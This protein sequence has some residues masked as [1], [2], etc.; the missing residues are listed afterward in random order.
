MLQVDKIMNNRSIKLPCPNK[1][2]KSKILISLNDIKYNKTVKCS[3]C[4]AK[5]TLEQKRNNVSKF[6]KLLKDIPKNI[7]IKL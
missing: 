4:G 3:S 1:G 5:V 2:C 7:I 6:E